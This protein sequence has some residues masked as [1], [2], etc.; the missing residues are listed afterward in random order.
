MLIVDA[1]V[2]CDRGA[3]LAAKASSL[4]IVFTLGPA[5]SERQAAMAHALTH[6]WRR[7]RSLHHSRSETLPMI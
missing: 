1:T 5:G 7:I 3:D 4:Q 2:F 6:A